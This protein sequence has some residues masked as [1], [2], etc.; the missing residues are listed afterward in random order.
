VGVRYDTSSGVLDAVHGDDFAVYVK[1]G[2]RFAATEKLELDAGVY[3]A[4][5]DNLDDRAVQVN[6][7]YA[8][9]SVLD[10]NFGVDFGSDINSYHGGLR[11]R[12]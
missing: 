3:F 5:T 7:Y 11:F 1:P 6:A 2:I 4:S 10:L 9:F 12:W 8:L